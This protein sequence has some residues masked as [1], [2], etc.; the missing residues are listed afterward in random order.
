MKLDNVKPTATRHTL[1][2]IYF[3]TFSLKKVAKILKQKGA[4]LWLRFTADL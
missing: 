1:T 3:I 4:E 2:A